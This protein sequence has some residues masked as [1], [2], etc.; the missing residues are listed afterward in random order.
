MEGRVGH[1]NVDTVTH[2]QTP[3]MQPEKLSEGEL[4]NINEESGCDEKDE[5]ILKK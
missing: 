5:D 4:V 1:G 3:D 2:W